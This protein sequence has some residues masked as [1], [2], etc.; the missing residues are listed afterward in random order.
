M[1]HFKTTYEPSI[2]NLSVRC[3]DQD[4]FV[5]G[6]EPMYGA[7]PREVRRPDQGRAGARLRHRVVAEPLRSGRH[8][9]GEGR[10]RQRSE[11]R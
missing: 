6:V 3:D 5:A 9:Q 1:N 2:V 7:R 11:C 4:L 10:L 8:L